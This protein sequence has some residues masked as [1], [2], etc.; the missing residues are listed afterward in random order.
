MR[1][2]SCPEHPATS[3]QHWQESTS[4]LS[5]IHRVKVLKP[6][7]ISEV[8]GLPVHELLRGEMRILTDVQRVAPTRERAGLVEV[9]Q[10]PAQGAR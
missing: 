4:A 5:V 9:E 10:L 8:V 1:K 7:R 3:I 2:I 6:V